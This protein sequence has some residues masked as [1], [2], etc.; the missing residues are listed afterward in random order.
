MLFKER[1]AD[2]FVQTVSEVVFHAHESLLK[3]IGWRRVLKSCEEEIAEPLQRVLIHRI[4]TGKIQ[5]AEVKQT[6][7]KGHRTV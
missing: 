4:D 5:D 6:S 7:S 2:V 3:D 1:T